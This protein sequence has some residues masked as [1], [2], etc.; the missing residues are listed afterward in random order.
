MTLLWPLRTPN[1]L[2]LHE[3]DVW[4]WTLAALST[5]LTNIRQC[6][7]TKNVSE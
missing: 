5:T 3:V 4:A 1:I 2:S 6:Y 7:R